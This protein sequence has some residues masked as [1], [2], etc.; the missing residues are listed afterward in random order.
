MEMVTAANVMLVITNSTLQTRWNVNFQLAQMDTLLTVFALHV[1]Q[2]AQL[3]LA[4]P[5]APSVQ[6]TTNFELPFNLICVLLTIVKSCLI[7]PTTLIAITKN[8]KFV[9]FRN[10]RHV[11][12]RVMGRYAKFVVVSAFGTTRL[13]QNA[14]L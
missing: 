7:T 3:A 2:D 8:A 6:L 9:R 12:M 14:H 10:V 5:S 13:V 4:R 11:K 1:R